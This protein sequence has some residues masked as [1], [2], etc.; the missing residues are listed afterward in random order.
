MVEAAGFDLERESAPY[1]VRLGPA[2]PRAPRS[3]KRL[4]GELRMRLVT[5]Q[6]GVP[7][8]AVLAKV[9]R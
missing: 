7:H 9:V 4:I 3:L 1:C 2:H 5:R 8:A 6:I